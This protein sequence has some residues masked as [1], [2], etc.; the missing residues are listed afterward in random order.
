MFIHSLLFRM[1][2]CTAI[3]AIFPIPL[4]EHL[5]LGGGRPDLI[6]GPRQL[7]EPGNGKGNYKGQRDRRTKSDGRGKKAYCR[8]VLYRVRPVRGIVLCGRCRAVPLGPLVVPSL[9][10]LQ[11]DDA[12]LLNPKVLLFFIALLLFVIGIAGSYPSLVLSG[13]NPG[14]S[15]VWPI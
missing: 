13:F 5:P 11:I 7:Y 14:N 10:Q 6:A 1:Y 12:F 4:S 15:S 9:L 3:M 8:S 2:T